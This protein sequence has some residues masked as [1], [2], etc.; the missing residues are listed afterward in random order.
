ME[1]Y[2]RRPA[3]GPNV[4]GA[5]ALYRREGMAPARDS[6]RRVVSG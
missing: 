3:L 4:Y 2:C 1:G 5:G 6:E